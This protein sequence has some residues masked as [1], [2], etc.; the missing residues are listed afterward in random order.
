M[1]EVVERLEG[2]LKWSD[3]IG[4][5]ERYEIK[6]L[7]KLIKNLTTKVSRVEVINHQDKP[8]GRVYTKHDCENVELSLQDNGKTLKVFI[9]KKE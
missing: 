1:T 5:D 9:S 7:V 8:I 2:I 4:S 3:R 6:A